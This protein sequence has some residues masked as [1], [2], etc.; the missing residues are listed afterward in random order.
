[1]FAIPWAIGPQKRG[2]QRLAQCRTPPNASTSES[3]CL[4]E[5]TIMQPCRT[6]GGRLYLSH[7]A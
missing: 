5:M 1:M 7:S 3:Y 6:F 4:R 2:V